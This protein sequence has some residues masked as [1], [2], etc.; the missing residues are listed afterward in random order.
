MINRKIN[1]LNKSKEKKGKTKAEQLNLEL[2]T[3]NTKEETE[4]KILSP[5][6]K[7]VPAEKK[8]KETD[9]SASIFGYE[10]QIIVGIILSFLNIE[11]L[12]RIEIE[13][14]TEDIELY[15]SDRKP[16]YIQ[17][18]AVQANPIDTKDNYKA[19]LAM[20]TLINTSNR[21]KGRYSKLMYV[22]NFANP[23]DL[24][25]DVLQKV[26]LPKK[27][28]PF[29]ASYDSLPEVAKNLIQARI[30]KARELLEKNN[31]LSTIKFFEL[32]KLY[33]MT[34][35]YNSEDS[36]LV[37]YQMLEATIENFFESID[38]GKIP[39]SKVDKIRDM[40]ISRYLSNGGSK[41]SKSTHEKITKK[42]LVWRIIFSVIDGPPPEFYNYVPV[43]IVHDLETY[44]NDF[45]QQQVEETTLITR[46]LIGFTKYTTR[47]KIRTKDDAYIF[48][49]EKW[50]EY[51]D[52][53]PADD[54]L[55]KEYG[56]KLIMVRIIYGQRKIDKIKKG[57][58]LK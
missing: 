9:A 43:E 27:D 49:N 4:K 31:H 1:K 29:E 42:S 14:E 20:N 22:A 21:V 33:I 13:G 2:D 17:V 24:P 50:R 25:D 48:I 26:W 35:L 15:F 55:L 58:N 7:K 36:S 12:T 53:F 46:I 54:E 5:R 19:V 52:I 32:K 57:A 10:F 8:P 3:L 34:M 11:K 41:E 47:L 30:K 51:S 40:F 18:K 39:K 28:T 6:D 44:E 37:K 45:I 56:T 23:I 16:E 38:F